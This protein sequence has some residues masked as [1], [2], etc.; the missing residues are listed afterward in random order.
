MVRIQSKSDW[1]AAAVEDLTEG[2]IHKVEQEKQ[3]QQ[4]EVVDRNT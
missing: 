2:E 4:G 1:P 3:G